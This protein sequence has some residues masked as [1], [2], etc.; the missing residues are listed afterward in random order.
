MTNKLLMA[1]III[2]AT[3]AI[4]E[5]ETAISRGYDLQFRL[6]EICVGVA[7]VIEYL[8]RLWIVPESPQ[9]AEKSWPRVRYAVSFAAVVDLL[10]II[11][12]V[13]AFGGGGSVVLRFLRLLRII[14][15][16]K[17]GR[18]SRAWN[19]IVTAIH[20]RRHELLL[21]FGLATILMLISSTLLYWAEGDLQP[22]KF[23]SIPRSFW[24]A[25][26]TLTT[27]GYG[28]VYPIT[29]LGKFLSGLVAVAGIGLI[30]MPTGI[31]A[32]AFSDVVQ[33]RKRAKAP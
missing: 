19:D 32:S 4:I 12:I 13:A 18:M 9:Y 8:A 25:V 29:A 2:A 6:F 20:S 7:F 22:D 5:T 14:R 3:A 26:V 24:W 21:T 10:A 23:G 30:A 15:L 17:L 11:P 33:A 28:D 27:V 1:L 31:L 16:A